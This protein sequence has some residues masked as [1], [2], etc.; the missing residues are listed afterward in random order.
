M[1]AAIQA[2]LDYQKYLLDVLQMWE[3]V[4]AQGFDPENVQSLTLHDDFLTIKQRQER[5]RLRQ[6]NG[7]DPYTEGRAVKW[8]NAIRLKDGSLHKLDPMIR[9]RKCPESCSHLD[10]PL[11]P[12]EP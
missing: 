2:K 9:R 1:I 6:R 12:Q 10:K 11:P 4:K 7:V 5:F 8:H 3:E